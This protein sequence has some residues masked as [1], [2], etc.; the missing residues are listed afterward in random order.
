M[1]LEDQ[2]ALRS[3]CPKC[4]ATGARTRRFAATGTGISRLF[5]IQHNKF[6]VVSC[7]N[8]GYTELYDPEPLEGKSNLGNVLDVLFGN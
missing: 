3:V 7:R 1:G 6:M 4:R 5:D 2:M 8:C